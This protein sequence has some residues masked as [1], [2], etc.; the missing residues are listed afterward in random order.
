MGHFMK[1][2]L[3]FLGLTA[4]K[5]C[6]HQVVQD[7]GQVAFDYDDY[8]NMAPEERLTYAQTVVK[9]DRRNPEGLELDKISQYSIGK[10]NKIGIVLFETQIKASRSGLAS[11]RNV[12]L[13][14][15][16]KQALTESF[17]RTFEFELK[18]ISLPM[19]LEWVSKDD[20]EA[21]RAFRAYG[22][23]YKDFMLNRS[24][25][26][27]DLDV[28]W[29]TGGEKIPETSLL[30]PAN[31]Q[32]VSLMY[33]PAYELMGGAKPS[34]HQHHWVNDLCKELGLD[35]VVVVSLSADW[36][37]GGLDKRSQ[38]LI[39]EKMDIS[40]ESTILYPWGTHHKILEAQKKSTN[41]KRNMPLAAYSAKVSVPVLI[42]VD[43]AQETFDTAMKNVIFPLTVYGESL[44]SLVAQRMVADIYQTY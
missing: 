7:G 33:V 30:L 27:S 11:D 37:R 20:L 13:S 19:A 26:L 16:G 41:Q 29:K 3:L 2:F 21:S 5:S 34:Q 1:W 14:E 23:V 17:Y 31:M 28:F 12:Y 6:A 24:K 36:S 25:K 40:V 43:P 35:A 10:I 15:S 22:S 4:L 9:R 18:K 8:K 42:T 44:L 39:P 38:A 32:D